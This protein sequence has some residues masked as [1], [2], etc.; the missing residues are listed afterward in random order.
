MVVVICSLSLFSTGCSKEEELSNS[1][2]L[3][4]TWNVSETVSGTTVNYTTTITKVD[5]N[6]ISISSDRPNP[7]VYFMNNLKVLVNWETMKLDG[8]GVV[9]G[10][11]TND[12]DFNIDYYYGAGSSVYD[13]KQ[14]YTR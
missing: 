7:P 14:H 12:K 11:I 9:S 1:D 2:K 5:D 3:T 6:N 4:G 8:P 10:S 13:V